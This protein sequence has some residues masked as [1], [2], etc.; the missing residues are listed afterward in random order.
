LTGLDTEL[1][2][3]LQESLGSTAAKD[4]FTTLDKA[5]CSWSNNTIR[6]SWWIITKGVNSSES[7][8]IR[9][10]ECGFSGIVIPYLSNLSSSS[11]SNLLSLNSC[12][13]G[14]IKSP[15]LASILSG[16]KSLSLS[17]NFLVNF[18]LSTVKGNLDG[19]DW[20]EGVSSPLSSGIMEG[21]L[22]INV[23]LGVL[24]S[25]VDSSGS[26]SR[27]SIFSGSS[28]TFKTCGPVRVVDLWS[29]VWSLT[30]WACT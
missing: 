1:G 9:L 5:D 12:F 28:S 15:D 18:E 22:G 30:L 29:S 17:C 20:I 26:G 27:S 14:I 24:G 16:K 10:V 23:G 3:I 4:V 13:L 7:F 25:E 21:L 19:V 2:S 6:I 8:S 11:V